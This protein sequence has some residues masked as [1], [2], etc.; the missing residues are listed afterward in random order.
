VI[1]ITIDGQI[2]SEWSS[3]SWMMT[4][5]QKSRLGSP[6][7]FD[8]ETSNFFSIGTMAARFFLVH[9][10]Q[11]REKCTKWTRNVSDYHKMS[12]MSVKYSKKP[13]NISTFSNQSPSK[14]YPNWEFWFEKKHLATL[15]GTAR[16][17]SIIRQ[18]IIHLRT[19]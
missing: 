8:G 10:T 14:I 2:H 4:S 3:T 6:K 7:I 16:P 19:E 15:I 12:Q 13:K 1:K 17:P 9:D 18:A 5:R 11:N